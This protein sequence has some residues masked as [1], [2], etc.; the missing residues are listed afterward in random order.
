MDDALTSPTASKIDWTTASDEDILAADLII[1]LGLETLSDEDKGALIH[2]MTLAVQKA[3]LAKVLAQ[4]DP[5]QKDKLTQLIETG[6]AEAVNDFLAHEV[7]DFADIIEAE[8]LRFKRAM[9]AGQITDV[10]V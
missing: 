5:Q 7:P 8:T 6:N 10:A 1:A 9:L 2:R 3:G 4:L